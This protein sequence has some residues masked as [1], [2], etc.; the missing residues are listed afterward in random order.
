MVGSVVRARGHSSIIFFCPSG[1]SVEADAH[2]VDDFSIF[3]TSWVYP[4]LCSLHHCLP[5][6]LHMT[7]VS[8]RVERWFLFT[9]HME[10]EDFELPCCS[11]LEVL[12][13]DIKRFSRRLRAGAHRA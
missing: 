3:H 9:Y 11:P 5:S 1:R 6:V 12:N 4:S 13:L 2:G 10:G 8:L 7:R